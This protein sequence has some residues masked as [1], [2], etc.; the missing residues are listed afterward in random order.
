MVLSGS[1]CR[2]YRFLAFRSIMSSSFHNDQET[3]TKWLLADNS[4]IQNIIQELIIK[5]K[6]SIYNQFIHLCKSM[7]ML[8]LIHFLIFNSLKQDSHA[9]PNHGYY[10]NRPRLTKLIDQKFN[11]ITEI[12]VFL[13]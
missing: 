2:G 4:I 5:I 10:N 1:N 12:V 9:I 13:A 8:N 11:N 6:S 3:F 7:T